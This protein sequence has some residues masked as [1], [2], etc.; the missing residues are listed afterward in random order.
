MIKII[1][2]IFKFSN[3]CRQGFPIK[4]FSLNIAE[5]LSDLSRVLSG[6]VRKKENFR[7]GAAIES[8]FFSCRSGERNSFLT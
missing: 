5:R 3:K 7:G 1:T 2:P 8:L 6:T 4:N